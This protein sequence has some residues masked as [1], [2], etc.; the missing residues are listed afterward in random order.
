LTRSARRARLGAVFGLFALGATLSFAGCAT[1]AGLDQEYREKGGCEAILPPAARGGEDPGGDIDFTVAL[2]QVDL[3]EQD[4]TPRYGYDLDAKCSCTFDEQS[5]ALPSGFNPDEQ[6]CDDARGLDNG[7]GV[8]LSRVSSFA[9]AAISS[10]VLN[11]GA[12]AGAWSLLVR[13]RGY[14]GGPDDDKVEVAVYETPGRPLDPPLWNGADVWPIA[15]TSVLPGSMSPDAP[16]LVDANAYVRGG[17][18]VARLPSLHLLFFGADSRL[19]FNLASVI[20]SARVEPSG[21]GYALVEGTIA[22]RWSLPEVF[23]TLSDFRFNGDEKLCRADIAYLQLKDIF[24]SAVDIA[25]EPEAGVPGEDGGV[26]ACDAI[27]FGIRFDAEPAKL[28][29]ITDPAPP[30]SNPCGPDLD[31]IGDRCM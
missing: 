27:S 29:A 15:N 20:L 2:R 24:C 9:A 25:L 23:A 1:I 6:I 4:E 16:L 7:T 18:L 19:S 21:G 13:V 14:A 31:P 28:G 30:P 8:A 10:P 17:I 26:P 22:G 12:T 3:D 11:A 5:C